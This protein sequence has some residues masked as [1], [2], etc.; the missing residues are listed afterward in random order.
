[1]RAFNDKLFGAGTPTDAEIVTAIGTTTGTG[2]LVRATSPVLVTPALGTPSSGTLTNC[3]GMPT[4]G[5]TGTLTDN[6]MADTLHRHSELS[7]SDGS[8]DPALSVDASGKVGIGTTSPGEK[9]EVA[10]AGLFTAQL[11]NYRTSATAIDFNSGVSRIWAF[12]PDATTAGTLK[13]IVS[14]NDGGPAVDALTVIPSGDVGIG[15]TSPTEQLD[16]S[17]DAI[18]IRTAQTPA[19]AGATGTTG[20]ICWDA[21]YVYVCVATNTWKRSAISTW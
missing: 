8:P 2:S 9:L 12:G 7:A 10:G 20:M 16:L 11:A 21:D 6:S 15:T 13:L 19:T 18:R 5:I 17:G 4:A 1:M 3:T 14:A